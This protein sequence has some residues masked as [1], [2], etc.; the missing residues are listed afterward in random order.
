MATD[1][2][3][4][5]NIE[6]ETNLRK[7][8]GT[9]ILPGI[10][11]AK[12]YGETIDKDTNWISGLHDPGFFEREEY[13]YA[14]ADDKFRISFLSQPPLHFLGVAKYDRYVTIEVRD[15]YYL[16][17]EQTKWR[18]KAYIDGEYKSTDC[19][20]CTP[21]IL[22]LGELDTGEHRI[23]VEVDNSMQYPYRPDGHGVSDALGG[24]W[25]GMVGEICLLTKD[26]LEKR[27]QSKIEYAKAHP[28]KI[29]I[30]N[31]KFY[32]DDKPTFLRGTHFGGDYPLT[33]FPECSEEWWDK[34]MNTIKAWGL[35]FI[36][37]HSYCPPKAAFLA[38][39]KAGVYLQPECGMW[40]HFEENIEM[41]DVL[42]NE[43]E[44]ILKA[45]GHH[46]S[47][48]LFSPTNEPSGKW[49]GVLREWVSKTIEYD[50]SLGYANRRVYTAQSGWF[51]DTMPSKT[52]GTDYLY[53]HRSNFG[54][55]FGGMI[56]NENGWKGKD[57]EPSVEDSLKPV[58]SH[59]LGQWCAY[60]DYDIISKFTGYLEPGNFEI[61]KDNCK[62]NGLL[63]L[64]K[65]MTRMSGENQVRL[66]KEDIEANLRTKYIEG[67]ELLELH[68]YLGQGTALVGIL[69]A[70]W[71][72]KGYVKPEEFREFCSETV[73]LA[74]FPSYV[75]KTTE[76]LEL[77]IDI[78]HYAGT[79]IEKAK[80]CCRLYDKKCNKVYQESTFEGILIL[81]GE[82][83]MLAQ[84]VLDF[85]QVKET[86]QLV[87]EAELISND[88]KV[89]SK[90]HWDLY[91][92]DCPKEKN[93]DEVIYTKDRDVAKKGLEAGKKVIYSPYLSDLGFDSPSVSIKNVFWNSQMGPTWQRSLGLMIRNE[94]EIFKYF[95]TKESGGWQWENILK[96]SRALCIQELNN[97]KPIVRV[98]DDW[99]RNL[100]LGIIFEAKVNKGRLLFVS[101]D[102]DGDFDKRPEAFSLKQGIFEY[103]ASDNFNPEE[104]LDFD[105]LENQIFPVLRTEKIVNDIN[106]TSDMELKVSN[107]KNM[108]LAN[109]N[110]STTI[111]SDKAGKVEIELCL[112]KPL[113]IKGMVYLPDQRE[114]CRDSFAKD[115]L[116][117][118]MEEKT[119]K[120]QE[121]S[122]G[123][124]KNTSLSQKILF[125]KELILTKLRITIFNTYG[126]SNAMQWMENNEGYYQ[127]KKGDN[128]I[129]K[130]AGLHLICDE[131]SPHADILFWEGEELSTTKEIEA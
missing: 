92:Y 21:H 117:E 10:L 75:Y 76:K 109:P 70:F 56:R 58:I 123:S 95:P 112:E 1:L 89:I 3:G 20:L 49:Y 53:F 12:G 55:I 124:F 83:K 84:C 37:F 82:K 14:N 34:L 42:K 77:R 99:N 104:Q 17:I 46:P 4:K 128:Q 65:E 40:N 110:A 62:A 66:Y 115:Y 31:R 18:T 59:E 43:T 122:K 25:N 126:I 90:N 119:G 2:S 64:N 11:Q 24:T 22:P 81:D 131:D 121:L 57:Y 51:Y 96:R 78:A 29:E 79:D 19:S 80:L 60:P 28:R 39:D 8:S 111:E 113:L 72:E 85:S 13:K 35:N 69:D 105:I 7:Q 91:V 106:V 68:D 27:E 130:V 129:I 100:P 86:K 38:A 94:H 73:L 63:D 44:R 30:K 74:R 107:E 61:F 120:Y 45:Y 93:S 71:D 54:P 23:L 97:I 116:I 47:F 103:V 114:R 36:R 32:I 15:E 98:I 41:L 33:G 48:V 52:E 125:S 16:F 67:F 127:T 50:A 26:E 102:L 108:I 101:A 88:N 6:L 5:W 9:I 87:F 118:G